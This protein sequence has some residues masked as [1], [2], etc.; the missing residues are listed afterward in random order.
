MH[1]AAP[2]TRFSAE[3]LAL[4]H[5]NYDLGRVLRPCNKPFE[6]RDEASVPGRAYICR[7]DSMPSA[8][9]GLLTEPKGGALSL[10]P[11]N[12]ATAYWFAVADESEILGRAPNWVLL[13]ENPLQREQERLRMVVWSLVG[14]VVFITA[15]ASASAWYAAGR[16]LL[17]MEAIRA[18]FAKLSTH[19]L[20]RHVPL[21]RADNEI[22]RLGRTLNKTLDRLYT[23]VEQQKRFVADASH[24]LRTPLAALRTEL[25]LALAQ[26]A[27]TDWPRTVRDA[28]GDTL[29][30]QHLTTDLLL[31]ARLDAHTHDM[32]PATR[33]Y[34]D[35]TGLVREE[36]ARRHP[37]PDLAVNLHLS[38]AS[39]HAPILVHGH[40]VLLA[41]VLGNLLDNAERH[42]TSTITVRLTHHPDRQQAILEVYDDGPGIPLEHHAR[43][44]ER[45]TRLDDARAKDS[46]GAGLGL[47]L[48]H[49]ITTLHQGSLHITES[50]HGAH[51]T[52]CLPTHTVTPEVPGPPSP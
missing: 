32:R 42:A 40:R 3:N 28:L 12:G 5:H 14:A 16:V 36:V 23:A 15:V 10:W 48:A 4:A 24:E 44:F 46:G 43:V 6:V 20:D 7:W 25:E 52:A 9:K 21:P 39:A 13:A 17:P 38:N 22:S 31:L 27:T 29:R 11:F 51:L 37:P 34:V 49:H 1:Q 19:H 8:W 33:E 30:L 18:E 41:R 45:F 50:S 47:A 2:K 35:L 26:P